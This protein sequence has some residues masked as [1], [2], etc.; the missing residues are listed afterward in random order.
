M[1]AISGRTVHPVFALPGG[2]SRA[3]PP[4]GLARPCARPAPRLVALRR[5][6]PGVLP[7]AA[8]LE[9]REYLVAHRRGEAYRVRT[10]SMGMVD[11]AGPAHLPRRDAAG[12]RPGRRRG[13]PLRA[14]P[15][16]S[17]HLAERVEPWTYA[18]FTFL[19][20]RGWT[21]FT[22]GDESG[23]YRVGPAGP[24]QR[25]HAPW[26][27][28][29]PRRS[30]SGSSTRSAGRPTRPWPST[31][32][33]WWRRCRRPRRC[34]AG[35]R[36]AASPRATIRNVPTAAHRRRPRASAWSRR[37][38]ARSSTTTGPAAD[39]LLTAVNLVVAS[40]HN[41]APVQV[42]VRKAA[43][44]LIRGGEVD[45]GLLN[46]L[47][48]AFRAY[49][50]CN[51]CASHSLPGELP[52]LVTVTRPPRRGGAGAA[53]AGGGGR[54]RSRPPRTPTRRERCWS[55]A[56]ATR[57]AATTP[58]RSTWPGASRPRRRRA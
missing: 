25:G 37:R 48:M 35:R 15:T 19:K 27:R 11:E 56:S 42:S 5:G 14:R 21:G 51:A 20:A 54:S 29:A 34:G 39:G 22:E 53:A 18:K 4:E 3:L 58:W 38:A 50:P 13:G 2:C 52:L 49:D 7:D 46:R 36:P 44:G 43:R 33:G 30:G 45:D 47:E 9:Q 8:V 6:H 32:R 57:C 40:Q 16:T 24:A 26:P 23:L 55:S 10:H 31:G 12:H 1:A 28:R 17:T 41:A